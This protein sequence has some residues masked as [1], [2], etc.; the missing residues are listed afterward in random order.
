M[1]FSKIVFNFD[2]STDTDED[3]ALL[4]R[5]GTLARSRAH[6]MAPYW[7]PWGSSPTPGLAVMERSDQGRFVTTD[8]EYR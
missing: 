4:A 2:S 3:L 7:H 5:G 8:D 6:G 1:P